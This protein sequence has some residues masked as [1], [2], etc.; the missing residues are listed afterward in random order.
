MKFNLKVL[1]PTGLAAAAL[2]ATPA[3]IHLTQAQAFPPQAVEA[4]DLTPEQ[5][6]E[7]ETLWDN[8]RSQVEAVLTP[9]QQ[10]QLQTSL[11][12]GTPHRQAFRELDLSDE[13]R[14]AVREI[15]ADSRETGQ[16]ILTPE[17]QQ[18]LRQRM[19]N[20]GPGHRGG[21]GPEQALAALNL[22][23]EQQSQIDQIRTNTRSQIEAVL[24][25]E[26]RSTFQSNAGEGN[27]RQAF[28]ALNLSDEQRTEIHSIM[29][30]SRESVGNV[31]TEEQ[32]QQLQENRRVHRDNR[33]PQF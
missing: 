12:T 31:L 30:A 7:L 22:S 14:Q 28:R 19:A 27:F 1:I 33:G 23:P 32:K 25:E 5:Q 20:R 3:M 6:A 17:Q 4:L 2:I 29:D 9:Q 8:T 24:T 21:R 10:S 16:A 15:M 26:Q 18:Q 11:E 13:Q